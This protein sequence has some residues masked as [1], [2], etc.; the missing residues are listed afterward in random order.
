MNL[1]PDRLLV[2]VALVHEAHEGISVTSYTACAAPAS[3]VVPKL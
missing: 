3:A 2:E 1:L